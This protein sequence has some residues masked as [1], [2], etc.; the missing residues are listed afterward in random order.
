MNC[1][2]ASRAA[3]ARQFAH[4]PFHHLANRFGV[5]LRA[6]PAQTAIRFDRNHLTRIRAGHAGR[7]AGFVGRD[8]LV[9]GKFPRL[10]F[11][12]IVA[13]DERRRSQQFDKG[14]AFHG[15]ISELSET[16]LSARRV[17]P[18]SLHRYCRSMSR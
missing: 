8:G 7:R 3:L 10:P 16:P 17:C 18:R 11:G 5:D 13:G 4:S 6:I 1:R 14:S 9:R 12:R 15:F 2:Q